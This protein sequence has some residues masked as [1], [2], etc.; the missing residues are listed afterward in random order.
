MTYNAGQHLLN[1]FEG[2]MRSQI[3][4]HVAIYNLGH[5][6]SP[7]HFLFSFFPLNSFILQ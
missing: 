5:F 1:I 3:M 7:C 4:I 2:K 6:F